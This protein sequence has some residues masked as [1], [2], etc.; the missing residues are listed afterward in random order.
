MSGSFV[1]ARSRIHYNI[2]GIYL[3]KWGIVALKEN[4]VGRPITEPGCR[5][6]FTNPSAASR[7]HFL[8]LLPFK[9]NEF[10]INQGKL[11]KKKIKKAVFCSKC[12]QV[13]ILINKNFA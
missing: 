9:E 6:K 12:Y 11:N 1:N 3:Y 8:L 13:I 10:K 7:F 2:L 4:V 5:M